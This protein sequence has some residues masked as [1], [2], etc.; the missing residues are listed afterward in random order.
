MLVGEVEFERLDIPR[1]EVP[2]LDE[3]TETFDQCLAFWPTD[4]DATHERNGVLHAA[5]LGRAA[6][7]QRA[8]IAQRVA[9][10]L[11]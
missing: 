11:S 9:S 10:G 7:I 4:A 2:G 5:I 8:A 1:D 3:L 6:E